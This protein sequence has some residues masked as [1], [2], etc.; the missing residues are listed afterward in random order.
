LKRYGALALAFAVVAV[1]AAGAVAKPGNG[2]G[3]G[4]GKSDLALV[5][6]ATAAGKPTVTLLLAT[7]PGGAGAVADSLE[8]FGATITKQ[9]DRFGYVV[10]DVPTGKAVAAAK[11]QGV[12]A[13][14]VDKAVPAVD[15]TPD[16][17]GGTP[18]SGVVPPPSNLGPINPYM[19]TYRIGAPQFV[20]AHPTYDGR[21]VKVGIVDL[22]VDLD[23]PELQTAKTLDGTTVPK[24]YDW[25][26]WTLPR[27]SDSANGDPTWVPMA[28]VALNGDGQNIT[29]AAGKYQLPAA[30]KGT[31]DKLVFGVFA[32]GDPRLGG[33][34]GSDVNRDGDTNDTFGVLEDT[35]TKTVWVDV[36]QNGNFLDDTAMKDFAVNRDINHFG[37]DNKG[38]KGVVESM[39]F[40]VQTTPDASYVNIGIVSG[41]HGT[42]VAGTVAGKG[43]FNGAYDGVA[44]NAQLAVARVCLFIQGCFQTDQVA[45][46][47]YLITVDKVNIIQMSIGG[48]PALN[49]DGFDAEAQIVDNMTAQSGVQFFFSNGND[50]PGANTVG[51]PATANAAIGSGAYQS[52]DTWNANYANDPPKDDTLWTFSSRGPREDGGLKP[53]VV[54]PGSELSTWP[55]WDMSENPFAGGAGSRPYQLPP[56]YEMIQGTSM[57]SPMTA[58]A[59]ALLDSAALQ[60]GFA[61]TPAQLR[62]AIQ[63]S[64]RY[65]DGYQ[66]YEQGNGLVQV[67]AAWD[68]LKTKPSTAS[69]S[70]TASV[71]T[72][73]AQQIPGYQGYGVY[74]REGWTVGQSGDRTISFTGTPGTYT[75][76][77]LG[78]DGTFSSPTT[79]TVPGTLAVHIHVATGG[80]HSA[81]VRLANPSSA[82]YDY[83]VLNTIVAA[84][85][86]SAPSYAITNTGTADRADKTSFFVDV[87]PGTQSLQLAESITTGRTKLDVIDP[88]GVPVALTT[89]GPCGCV[90]DFATAPASKSL[91]LSNP[92]AGVW[93][94]DVEAS[95]AAPTPTSTAAFTVTE[96][97]ATASPAEWDVN[98]VTAGGTYT[99]HFTFTNQLGPFTG[100]AAGSPL[101]SAFKTRPTATAPD[102][103]GDATQ[104]FAIDVPSGATSLHVQIGNPDVLAQTDLDLYLFD[105]R[106]NL[107]ELSAGSTPNEQVTLDN[108]AAGT[109]FALVDDFAVGGAGTTKYDY[110]DVIGEP[111]LGSITTTDVVQPHANGSSWSFDATATPQGD[112]GAGRFWLGVV[113]VTS[114]GATVGKAEVDLR[115]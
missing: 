48:L 15:P 78:N 35:N 110:L 50:G 18:G 83:E 56:G 70:S 8:G 17:R 51:S 52:R 111:G 34:V 41:G 72:V 49:D 10:A 108:P 44:P 36:N 39:P 84:Q 59:A 46:F 67:G 19:P 86:F 79:V 87:A 96:L 82:G 1:L 71:N 63:S 3:K 91:T 90:E 4:L 97:G 95:R 24:I 28:Q 92:L 74:E 31:T 43:F 60:N 88:Q 21:G 47:D 114:G 5:A 73:L 14:D 6:Q 62:K 45:A 27:L 20:Q 104:V 107:L 2:H 77:W 115:P 85:Q 22:G 54:A 16:E 93:E 81:I 26:T 105:G 112:P 65:I 98:G 75:V 100:G 38:T 113:P 30:L 64:A 89:K 7:A 25:T 106:G 40:V 55:A 61:P 99:Q 80:I 11:S 23:R 32:E 103:N 94:I 13:A 53:N 102:A 68:I 12:L 101:G 66:A 109:Y 29:T 58:G 9:S 37:Q 57:A 76:S 69:I 42:H 33:E